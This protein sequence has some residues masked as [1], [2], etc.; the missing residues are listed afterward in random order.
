MAR[1]LAPRGWARR[2]RRPSGRGVPAG[3]PSPGPGNKG[4]GPLEQAP[5]VAVAEHQRDGAD[6]GQDQRPQ[7]QHQ[8]EDQADHDEDQRHEEHDRARQ[9][10]IGDTDALDAPPVPIGPRRRRRQCS[11]CRCP[12]SSCRLGGPL[13]GLLS[14][15]ACAVTWNGVAPASTAPPLF[16]PSLSTPSGRLGNFGD[17]QWGISVIRSRLTRRGCGRRS[18]TCYVGRTDIHLTPYQVAHILATDGQPAA[19]SGR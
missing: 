5:A 2:A 17:R 14:G 19:P 15:P 6:H 12:A 9:P 1:S 11:L 7:Q 8:R 10:E 3:G 18:C 16:S 13:R 4:R